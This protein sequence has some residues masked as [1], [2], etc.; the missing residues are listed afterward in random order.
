MMS[1]LHPASPLTEGPD[2]APDTSVL[3]TARR[4]NQCAWP[5]WSGPTDLDTARV[6]GAPVV[7]RTYC[8]HHY[9]MAYTGKMDGGGS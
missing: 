9:R 7:R 4:A 2:A 1:D 6:C 8:P 3:F 5:L